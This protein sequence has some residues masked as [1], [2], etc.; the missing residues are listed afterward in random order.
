MEDKYIDEW[1]FIY[2]LS[3]KAYSGY[4]QVEIYQ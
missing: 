1:L 4:T 2:M 3:S